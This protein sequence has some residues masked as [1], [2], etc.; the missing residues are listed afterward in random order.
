V[1]PA[2][3]AGQPVQ[4]DWHGPWLAP[5]AAHAAAVTAGLQRGLSVAQVL[6]ELSDGQAPVRFVPQSDLP[7]GQAYEAYIFE[8]GA[9]PTRDN[10]HDLF[11]GLSWLAFPRTKARLN[12][13]Q[14]AQIARSGVGDRRGP[15]R[16]ALTVFDEN[17]AVFLA[18]PALWQALQARHWQRLFI[19]LRGLWS[20]ARLVLF[21]HALQEKLQQPRK[22]ITAHVYR[23][24]RSLDPHLGAA[25]LDAAL[26]AD[27]SADHLAEKPYCPLPIL[28][29]P[30]WYLPNECVSFYDDAQVF[31]PPASGR[32]HG[33][34]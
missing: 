12:A 33:A 8:H 6:N 25:E 28:G 5:H 15:V 17:A 3:V 24:R 27:L 2:Q 19:D 14:A 7:P 9:C 21:G 20:Q 13:L 10:L 23:P 32:T 30:G 26:A 16:D 18:P 29:V 31:R 11:N 34:T 4:L 22:A 1:S